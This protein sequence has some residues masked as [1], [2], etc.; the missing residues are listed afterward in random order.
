M[1]HKIFNYHYDKNFIIKKYINSGAYGDIFLAFSQKENI[2]VCLKYINL[3]K[4][5]SSYKKNEINKSYTI[6]IENEISLLQLFSEYE[7]SLKYYGC[8]FDNI[9]LNT[10]VLILEKCDENLEEYMK[11]R[12]NASL[13]L[14]LIK[15]IFTGIN[16]VFKAMQIKKIIHR[17][18][19]LKNLLVKYIDNKREKFI[20]KLSD[21]GIGKYLNK[22]NTMTGLKGTF[23]TIAPEIILQKITKYENIEDIFSLGVILYQL[24]HNLKHPYDDKPYDG[25]YIQENNIFNVYKDNFDEDNYN[26]RIDNSI[27]NE[28]FKDLLTKM[29]KLNPKNRLTWEKYFNHPFFK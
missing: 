26:I 27:E 5:K 6:D 25:N 23:E 8:Y 1:L 4:M 7:N 10:I 2:F 3:D 24:S 13:N 11:N 12:N 15:E 19:K 14:N 9:N 18:L 16:K 20:V 29:L 17:D 21:Y 22:G 28:D